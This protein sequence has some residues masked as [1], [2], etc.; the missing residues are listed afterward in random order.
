M[1]VDVLTLPHSWINETFHVIVEF[2]LVLYKTF[3]GRVFFIN[4]LVDT[5]SRVY[6]TESTVIGLWVE[7]V[8][9]ALGSSC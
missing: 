3:V 4:N 8:V 2:L 9:V 7:A 1:H 5:P 6:A